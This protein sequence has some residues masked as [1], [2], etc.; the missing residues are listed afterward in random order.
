MRTLGISEVEAFLK[1]YAAKASITRPLAPLFE[2]I[3]T[4][5]VSSP[6]VLLQ[7]LEKYAAGCPAS[8]SATGADGSEIATYNLCKA[9]TDG[10][11]PGVVRQLSDATPDSARLI[12]ASAAGWLRKGLVS[13][14][15]RLTPKQQEAA[16]LGLIE[17]ANAPFEDAMMLNWLYGVL[18]KIARRYRS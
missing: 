5:G 16:A 14:K 9:L 13:P 18:W 10:D 6:G 2:A 4:L 7:A 11:W 12:R 3:H 1:T 17:L 8:D 15:L